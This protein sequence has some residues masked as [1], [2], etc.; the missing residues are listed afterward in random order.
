MY[1]NV[2]RVLDTLDNLD[3]IKSVL[4]SVNDNQMLSKTECA[5]A[6]QDYISMNPNSKVVIAA[7]WFGFLGSLLEDCEVTIFD[8]DPKCRR[9]GRKL[10]PHLKHITTS[11][12]EFDPSSY[13][14]IIC[15]ACEHVTDE[16]LNN[17]IEK[18]GY[19]SIVCLQSNDYFEISDHINCKQTLQ[20]F[21]DSVNLDVI[22]SK[23][24]KTPK[25]NRFM[26]IGR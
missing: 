23:I 14:T 2:V 20:D 1:K 16:T 11:M 4:N 15:T 5:K 19:G 12:E 3:E 10:Y 7:G 8:Q 24:I 13:G 18:R 22:E 17:F 26:I 9:I 21:I 25:Y 6:I